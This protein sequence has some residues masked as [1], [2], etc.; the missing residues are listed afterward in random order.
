LKGRPN[1][2]EFAEKG[3]V[4]CIMG[5]ELVSK[6]DVTSDVSKEKQNIYTVEDLINNNRENRKMN[7][8]TLHSPSRR[9]LVGSVI[10]DLVYTGGYLTRIIV[11]KNSKTWIISA[12][13]HAFQIKEIETTQQRKDPMHA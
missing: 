12:N 9:Q 13:E 8:T 10:K 6:P 3:G 11:E 5:I 1:F 7:T 4:D 2:A